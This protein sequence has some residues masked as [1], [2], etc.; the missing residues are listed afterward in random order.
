MNRS[1]LEIFFCK[2]AKF[3]TVFK[4]QQ[5][6][7]A[8]EMAAEDPQNLMNPPDTL[9]IK[10]DDKPGAMPTSPGSLSPTAIALAQDSSK[11]LI[12]T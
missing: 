1:K 11:E 12:S 4:L 10:T 7:T 6:V 9:D 5:Q 8:L 3:A 2:W